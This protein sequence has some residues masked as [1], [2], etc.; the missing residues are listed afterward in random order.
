MKTPSGRLLDCADNKD[1]IVDIAVN[2]GE[3]GVWTIYYQAGTIHIEG[4]PP[5]LGV[6]PA[7][8][9]LPTYLKQSKSILPHE[10]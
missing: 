7:R 4:V 3:S 9:L 8:M 1:Q 5:Y 6:W 10:N 2:P